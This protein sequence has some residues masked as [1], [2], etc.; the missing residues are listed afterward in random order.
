MYYT[1][2]DLHR[3]ASLLNSLLMNWVASQGQR[4]SLKIQFTDGLN[5]LLLKQS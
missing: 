2:M 4:V 1:G 5:K 3:E